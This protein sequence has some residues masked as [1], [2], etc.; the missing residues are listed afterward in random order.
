MN[1]MGKLMMRIGGLFVPDAKETVEMMYKFEQPF[2]VDSSKFE[3]TFGTKTTPML[4]AIEE[5]VD[6]YRNHPQEKR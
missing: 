1:D 2:I 4:E 6:W 3:K 5:T